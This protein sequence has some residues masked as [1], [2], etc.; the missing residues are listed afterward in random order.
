MTQ[1]TP[2]TPQ[3]LQTPVGNTGGF[4]PFTP[5]LAP[6]VRA[7]QFGNTNAPW[8]PDTGEFWQNPE[9][10]APLDW[11]RYSD[12]RHP[13]YKDTT[14]LNT[15]LSARPEVG[16]GMIS[17]ALN[18]PDNLELARRKF[19]QASDENLSWA[20]RAF[21]ALD[22]A[23]VAAPGV[24]VTFGELWANAGAAEVSKSATNLG[25][26]ILSTGY[27]GTKALDRLSTHAAN[28]LGVE[29]ESNLADALFGMNGPEFN[30]RMQELEQRGLSADPETLRLV[31]SEFDEHGVFSG[32]R[33]ASQNPGA[34]L[35]DVLQEYG[36][37]L[38][39]V[40]GTGGAAVNAGVNPMLAYSSPNAFLNFGGEVEESIAQ[41]KDIDS[42]LTSGALK[43]GIMFLGDAATAGLVGVPLFKAKAA[44][45]IAK[46]IV[47]GGLGPVTLYG[48]R[49]ILN[50]EVRASELALE[51]GLGALFETPAMLSA[52]GK[53]GADAPQ[54]IA[55]RMN[56]PTLMRDGPQTEESRRT[57]VQ[58]FLELMNRQL[59]LEAEITQ[60]VGKT[61][62][63]FGFND[64]SVNTALGGAWGIRGP[65]QQAWYQVEG[66]PQNF[67]QPN[68]QF[69]GPDGQSFRPEFV[70]PTTTA[71]PALTRTPEIG[72]YEVRGQ[73]GEK[74][75]SRNPVTDVE[76]AH[77]GR[78]Q[79][80]Q[81]PTVKVEG[82]DVSSI[83]SAPI[84]P[85]GFLGQFAKDAG[86]VYDN[87]VGLN[88]LKMLDSE[89]IEMFADLDGHLDFATFV[90]G[91]KVTVD[92][93]GKPR[94]FEPEQG[95]ALLAN[96][97]RK[98]EVVVALGE[99]NLLNQRR[100]MAEKFRDLTKAQD[101]I[102]AARAEAELRVLDQRVDLLMQPWAQLRR[103]ISSLI[104][105][106]DPDGAVI[107][108]DKLLPG[109]RRD[110][111]GVAV[112]RQ[113]NETTKVTRYVIGI[114]PTAFVN[115][116][117]EPGMVN[118]M[119]DFEAMRQHVS[120]ALGRNAIGKV[121]KSLPDKIQNALTVQFRNYLRRVTE[122]PSQ[123]ITDMLSMQGATE[124][125]VMNRPLN[126]TD[127]VTAQ[128][129][130]SPEVAK[131]LG[132]LA[133]HANTNITKLKDWMKVS[134]EL[135]AEKS[136][137]V[138][139]KRTSSLFD[140]V[141]PS[142]IWQT[143]RAESDWADVTTPQRLYDL[144]ADKDMPI[145]ERK[146]LA[147][148]LRGQ[149]LDNIQGDLR[150]NGKIYLNEVAPAFDQAMQF[151]KLRSESLK[152]QSIL[153]RLI[154]SEARE[155]KR[156]M[157]ADE[158]Y[159]AGTIQSMTRDTYGLKISRL[160]GRLTEHW[161]RASNNFV[162]PS[163]A[164]DA[165][166]HVSALRRYSALNQ[167][168]SKF[169][170]EHLYDVD[171]IANEYYDLD[172]GAQEAVRQWWEYEARFG[173]MIDKFRKSEFDPEIELALRKGGLAQEQIDAI[174]AGQHTPDYV[175]NM[176]ALSPEAL[177]VGRKM[178]QRFLR[179]LD[180]GEQLEYE[181]LQEQFQRGEISQEG[182]ETEVRKAQAR[183]RDMRRQPYI[184]SLRLGPYH[185][186]MRVK[187][188]RSV[189]HEGE[190]FDNGTVLRE[191]FKNAKDRDAAIA[192][193][194]AEFG[195]E[196]VDILSIDKD[197]IGADPNTFVGLPLSFWRELEGVGKDVP[198]RLKEKYPELKPLRAD[199]IARIKDLVYAYAPDTSFRKRMMTK[200]FTRGAD[201][202][203]G[204]SFI[205]ANEQFANYVRRA[206]FGTRMR[207][208]IN[209]L[210]T[211]ITIQQNVDI[212][213][214]RHVGSENIARMQVLR[215][216]MQEHLGAINRKPSGF[217]NGLRSHLNT[218]YF[219]GN[220][221]TVAVQAAQFAQIYADLSGKFGSKDALTQLA[222][223]GKDAI[224]S[225]MGS[226]N[227]TS[228]ES[229]VLENLQKSGRIS[230]TYI[231]DMVDL[232]HMERGKKRH[233]QGYAFTGADALGSTAQA[234]R[235]A[236]HYGF[237][238]LNWMEQTIRRTNALATVRLAERQGI[239]D[240][241]R[242]TRLAEDSIEWG[243]Y[244]FGRENRP[245]GLAKSDAANVLLAFMSIVQK[246]LYT[247][248][249]KTR[250]NGN[251]FLAA[252][253]MLGGLLG[254]PFM[255]DALDTADAGV[256]IYNKMTGDNK[257]PSDLRNEITSAIYDAGL[258]VEFMMKGAAGSGPVDVHA[259]IT[260]GR[261]IPGG[262][263]DLVRSLSAGMSPKDAYS[264]LA[265]QSLGPVG[266]I[267]ANIAKAFDTG[268]Y[269]RLAPTGIYN[270]L[271]YGPA[272]VQNTLFNSPEMRARYDETFIH[273]SY[274]RKVYALTTPE[275][276]WMMALGFRPSEF[277]NR[278]EFAWAQAE[279]E[280]FWNAAKGSVYD[281]FEAAIRSGEPE[282]LK[283]AQ[284]DLVEY[285]RGAPP[286]AKINAEKLRNM[287]R[288]RAKADRERLSP[289]GRHGDA[290]V[291]Y[292]ELR[293]IG[294]TI[295][296]DVNTY[297]VK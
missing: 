87:L 72:A 225:R 89:S 41:G 22:A 139:G 194:R 121:Y 279:R 118:P 287:L 202:D 128:L 187:E 137:L 125:G 263:P 160:L 10:P 205:V 246:G 245:L 197:S 214:D 192:E 189:V 27:Y 216:Y 74:T 217:W 185:V 182:M 9:L 44:D 257:G 256:N 86:Q 282:E 107:I 229:A 18:L 265:T 5:T 34:L 157:T 203:L 131:L 219:I 186:V 159:I 68:A 105:S 70:T 106:F 235:A 220:A 23:M 40:I 207:Q 54:E 232:S 77:L 16:G 113:A 61:L 115:K 119:L 218:Y 264:R 233:L 271:T 223:A 32:L 276:Q 162:D 6:P 272:A 206:H 147:M 64:A 198:D 211:E 165:Q 291:V 55:L 49:T 136:A 228:T 108:T 123:L 7:D 124:P 254:M 28:L 133:K 145:A 230:T 274:G 196:D 209:D 171:K 239:N 273:N 3:S 208:A 88:A 175:V 1:Y 148:A 71:Q 73:P 258:P 141:Q 45:A 290:T 191:A 122:E 92:K 172:T 91:L 296:P 80:V 95:P 269:A 143:L 275:E 177:A 66:G 52:F 149:N 31:A 135:A 104:K 280:M 297:D 146:A 193:L 56:D 126:F 100:A 260:Y 63:D 242:L 281:N 168:G 19:D 293:G 236:K 183:Y 163:Q 33:A 288:R 116:A 266:G 153:G 110:M 226:A 24:G 255:E 38:A 51:F 82:N 227:L 25:S 204:Q 144:I 158:E 96:T 26:S 90:D 109:G 112:Q 14:P 97:M 250:G 244:M 11:V 268:D 36:L 190:T 155:R 43:T 81:S 261:V 35:G 21:A 101:E 83:L 102:G 184:P 75:I 224:L 140:P 65:H 200:K 2:W 76:P 231:Q 169:V 99:V 120:R 62:Q 188:G 15:A 138:S 127:F 174:V 249:R 252:N 201:T 29:V 154:G 58:R 59:E 286:W 150:T 285:N 289:H 240:V 156:A 42:A 8:N 164:A 166:P 142:R 284:E 152:D 294:S 173:R 259:S 212:R 130:D 60:G 4:T 278:Q 295:S 181:M 292:P 161:S 93:K 84:D 132:P 167:E 20:D 248:T 50:E 267:G 222:L 180:K 129:I 213:S 134:R 270:A 151:E 234:M 103:D 243:S 176:F 210:Q 283:S 85:L 46:S 237:A 47:G 78:V 79:P 277:V 262:L 238:P 170:H 251:R 215:Q 13:N 117:G 48:S 30:N 178:R 39:A 67:Q 111:P 69:A 253:F 195:P 98:G 57:N 114:D 241:R 53:L 179:N 12:P 17:W 94:G 221:K 199:Q 37:T 247:A